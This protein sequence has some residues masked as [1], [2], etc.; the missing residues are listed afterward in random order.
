MLNSLKQKPTADKL[1]LISTCELSMAAI[2]KEM[3]M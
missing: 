1:R 3:S 2:Q